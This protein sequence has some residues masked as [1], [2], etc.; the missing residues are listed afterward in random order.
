VVVDW[1]TQ[2]LFQQMINFHS[3]MAAQREVMEAQFAAGV[4]EIQRNREQL[5]Q[6]VA[7]HLNQMND[8]LVEN[9]ER[10]E[11]FDQEFLR[12]QNNVFDDINKFNAGK[13]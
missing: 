4:E 10:V 7:T 9:Q 8:K 2:R 12:G 6:E 13:K 1:F 3:S 5:K 11:E